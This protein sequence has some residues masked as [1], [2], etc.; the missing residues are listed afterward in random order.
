M[1]DGPHV[2]T[3]NG[4]ETMAVGPATTGQMPHVQTTGNSLS[5]AANDLVMSTLANYQQAKAALEEQGRYVA[6]LE[7]KIATQDN[8]IVNLKAELAALDIPRKDGIV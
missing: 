7:A 3:T 6:V 4:S 1:S 8:V 2:E 5:D